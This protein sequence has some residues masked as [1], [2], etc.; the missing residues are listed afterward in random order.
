MDSATLQLDAKPHK[1]VLEHHGRSD[2][3]GTKLRLGIVP[4]D[5]IVDR[6]AKPLAE[7]ADM[8]VVAVGFDP[9]TESEGADRMFRL[10]PGQEQLVQEMQAA[11]KNIVVVITSGGAVDM[12]SWQ[13]RVPAVLQAWYPG[14]AGGTALAEILFGDVNPSGH[15][16]ASFERRWEDNPVHDSYY[17]KP[18]T[19]K[20]P[21]K[22]GVFVGYR[23]YERSGKKPLF[24]FGYGLSYTTFSYSN[25]SI[26]NGV[27]KSGSNSFWFAQVSFDVTNTGQRDGA[28]V[29]QVYVSGPHSSV[30]R[31]AKE[32]KGFT[33]IQLKPGEKRT[34]T[35]MLDKR[36]LSYYDVASKQWRA[37]PG[38]YEVMVGSSSADIQLRGRLVFSE[39][40][41][42]ENSAS[43][44]SRF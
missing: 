20:V 9:E 18:G 37:D 28:E 16:P 44:H 6:E 14:E 34:V 33:K 11:N 23:G 42:A 3:L 15:L 19:T 38:I 31:P 1:I 29:A 4:H 8:V 24:P 21:Y 41:A 17:P 40:D 25:L 22:E 10:P 12:N 32:L 30:E 5:E 13:D 27:T 7:K 36:A 26:Q 39:S 2:W 43:V 35:L